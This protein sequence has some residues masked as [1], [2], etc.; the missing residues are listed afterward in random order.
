[1]GV[2]VYKNSALVYSG[3][4]DAKSTDSTTSNIFDVSLDSDGT[5]TIYT[6]AYDKAGNRQNQDPNN[7]TWYYQEYTIDTT[8][9]VT[10]VAT[11]GI[12]NGANKDN[13]WVGNTN[14]I[15]FNLKCTVGKSG[16]A[17][18]EYTVYDLGFTDYQGNYGLVDKNVI[19]TNATQ[20]THLYTSNLSQKTYTYSSTNIYGN[21]IT[22]SRNV[23]GPIKVELTCTNGE[24]NKSAVASK[25]VK[26]D[27]Q[28]KVSL[29]QSTTT[30]G[31]TATTTASSSSGISKYE[32][33]IDSN[34][35]IDNGTS[36]AYTFAGVSASTDHTIY[37]MVTNNVGLASSKSLSIT[38]SIS[39]GCS[40]VNGSLT[41]TI[42]R[43]CKDDNGKVVSSN[44]VST[45]SGSCGGGGGGG[46][47]T[48]AHYSAS[49]QSDCI[50]S[51]HSEEASCVTGGQWNT[52]YCESLGSSC[53]SNCNRGCCDKWE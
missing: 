53:Y 34:S 48:C 12:I 31:I 35:W 5:W 47:Q 26:I 6:Q 30:S 29:T 24:G 16:V 36:N 40:C 13:G 15:N 45:C 23:T 14:S 21:I 49:C 8:D 41:G 1:M 10:P 37:T 52:S 43:V 25:T 32:F 22:S 20:Q 33:K 46:G 17:S 42:D 44:T 11:I 4:V 50:K 39:S 9:T 18:Y 28:P 3:K 38:C 27:T 7:G 19:S 51:C 2:H